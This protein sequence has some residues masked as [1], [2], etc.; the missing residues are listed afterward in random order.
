MSG[1]KS[2]AASTRHLA[3]PLV[4]FLALGLAREA[5]ASSLAY[6]GFNYLVNQP[7][8]TMNGGTGWAP[9]VWT[10]LSGGMVDQPP[11][12]SYPSALPS[13]GDAL[14][15]LATGSA[16]RSFAAPFSNAGSDLWFSFEELTAIG[17]VPGALVD[18]RQPTAVL[19]DI[20]VNKDSSGAITLNGIAAGSSA[21]VGFVDFFVLQLVQFG[22]GNTLVNLYVDPGAVLG[23]PSASVMV[24]GPAFQA[25]EFDYQANAGQ[26]LDE[27]RV[28]TTVSDIAAVP[29]P[30]TFTLLA[31]AL[32]LLPF[33]A[34]KGQRS[35]H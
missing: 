6:E 32:L 14:M 17:A 10:Q 16:S 12:L 5:A 8:P 29:E 31:G 11:S 3:A 7:L 33:A 24:A 26:K 27:I 15:T 35:A 18:I 23:P 9:G 2:A 13:S 4:L 25:Q 34:R 21:G 19:P 22:G 28:G 1:F 20:A 30:A